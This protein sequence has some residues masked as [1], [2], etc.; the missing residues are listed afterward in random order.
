LTW[1][2]LHSIG[3]VWEE[4]E[5]VLGISHSLEKTYQAYYGGKLGDDQ[6]VKK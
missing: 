4:I 6:L 1:H 2:Q 5:E 3:D